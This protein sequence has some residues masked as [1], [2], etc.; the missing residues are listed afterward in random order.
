[1]EDEKPSLEKSNSVFAYIGIVSQSFDTCVI[2]INC[3]SWFI[4]VATVFYPAPEMLC[5]HSNHKELSAFS[6]FTDLKL[7]IPHISKS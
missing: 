1:M 7:F 3:S 4:V 5:R 2:Y 6:L